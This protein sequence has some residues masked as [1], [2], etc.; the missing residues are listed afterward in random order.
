MQ[1][2]ERQLRVPG[3]TVT[4]WHS[5]ADSA[6]DETPLL[7]LHGGPGGSCDGFAVFEQLANERP[8]VMWDQLGS[9]RSTWS[10]APEELWTRDRFCAEVDAVR[11]AFDLDEVITF[12]HS[13]GG[14]LSMDYLSRQPDGVVAAVLSSTSASYSSFQASIDRRVADLPASMRAAVDRQRR[15]GSVDE[16][17]YHHAALEFYRRFVVRNVPGD[18]VAEQVLERQRSSEVFQWMQGADELHADGSLAPWSRVADLPTITAPVLV[19]VG[20]FD[21]LDEHCAAEI[22]DGLTSA[23]L[24]R[25]EDSSHCP[26]LEQPDEVVATVRQFINSAS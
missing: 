21:H 20:R 25:F 3:G 26:H 7:F 19:T 16:P 10:G 1:R 13:W 14:W 24:V 9:R 4:A 18:A 12:G 22:A 8:V 23:E 5:A 11:A 6:V 2:I 17:E 15:G